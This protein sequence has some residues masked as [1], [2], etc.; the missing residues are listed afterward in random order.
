MENRIQEASSPNG[1]S[2]PRPFDGSPGGEPPTKGRERTDRGHWKEK[3]SQPVGSEDLQ[4]PAAL[5]K[6]LSLLVFPG[7]SA[8]LRES[9][10]FSPLLLFASCVIPVGSPY[11]AGANDALLPVWRNGRRDRL[12]ICFPQGSGGSSPSTGTTFKNRDN[13]R[14]FRIQAAPPAESNNESNNLSATSGDAH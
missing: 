6:N 2:G 7:V 4:H 8:S 11:H 1:E 5:S 14:F 13:L 12:K 3:V 10:L 9:P